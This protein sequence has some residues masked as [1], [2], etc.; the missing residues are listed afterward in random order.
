M[1]CDQLDPKEL[2]QFAAGKKK[3]IEALKVGLHAQHNVFEN[4]AFDFMEYFWK[5]FKKK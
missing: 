5:L 4:A 3:C 2:W 1:V